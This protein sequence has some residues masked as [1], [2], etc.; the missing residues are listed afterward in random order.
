MSAHATFDL[1]RGLL[2][3]ARPT[4]E[5]LRAHRL[6]A[7]GAEPA[8][9]EHLDALREAGALVDGG[10]H[11]EIEAALAPMERPVCELAVREGDRLVEGWMSPAAVTLVLPAGEGSVYVSVVSPSLLPWTLARLAGLGPRPRPEVAI[12]LR[13]ARQDLDSL[14][15]AAVDDPDAVRGLI[16][17]DPPVTAARAM[18]G[19][20]AGLRVRWRVQA[21]WPGPDGRRSERAVEM[22]DTEG[23]LWLIE[24]EAGDVTLRPITPTL[25]WRLLIRVLP[26]EH[27]IDPGVLVSEPGA[28]P[29]T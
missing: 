3:L 12:G 28:P 5:V 23:G 25:A 27:E 20:A 17:G 19:L 2:R 14:L 9:E 10:I 7:E 29:A 13:L 1:G 6:G 11:P 16:G 22:V 8:V 4:L 24:A 15:G 18:E 21:R 26:L